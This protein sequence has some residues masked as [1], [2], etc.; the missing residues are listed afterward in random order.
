MFVIDEAHCVNTWGNS[1]RPAYGQLIN[2][3]EFSRPIAAFTGTAT[4][5]TQEQIIEKLGLYKPEIH[6]PSC[7]ILHL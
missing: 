3:K 1:F 2:L 6:Q 7:S 5:E 4:H